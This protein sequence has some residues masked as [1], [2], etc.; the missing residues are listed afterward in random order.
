MGIPGITGMGKPGID[1]IPGI[2]GN[3]IPGMHGIPGIKQSILA[4]ST[5]VDFVTTST[6]KTMKNKTQIMDILHQIYL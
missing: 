2:F 5:L 6:A 3:G 1:G 4:P